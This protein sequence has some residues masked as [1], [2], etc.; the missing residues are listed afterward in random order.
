MIC[1]I[2]NSLAQGGTG[3]VRGV[4]FENVMMEDVA[5]PIIIDQFYCDSSTVCPNEVHNPGSI[6]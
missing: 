6:L 4:R 1:P 2:V 5:N 3:Y